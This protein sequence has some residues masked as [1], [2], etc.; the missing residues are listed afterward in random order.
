MQSMFPDRPNPLARKGCGARTKVTMTRTIALFLLFLPAACADSQS[1]RAFLPRHAAAV[2]IPVET[3]NRS[4]ERNRDLAASLDRSL[5]QQEER[6]QAARQGVT[7]GE[8][9]QYSAPKAD[10]VPLAALPGDAPS[11]THP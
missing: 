1:G 6:E 7:P 2:D 4:T 5:Q 3:P 9:A 8:A 11:R 10:R